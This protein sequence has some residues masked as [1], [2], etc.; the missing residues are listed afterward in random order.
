MIVVDTNVLIYLS[1]GGEKNSL[2]QAVRIADANWVLPPLWKH[3]YLNVLATYGKN[4][5][6]NLTDLRGLWTRAVQTFQPVEHHVDYLEALR[7][8][9]EYSISA[10]DAQYLTLALSLKVPL[11][12]EDKALLKAAPKHAFSMEQFRY[13]YNKS[14]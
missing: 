3:E 2:A 6:L 10:Y 14:V 5:H 4:G 11:I 13:S 1:I 7:V 12:T 8:S 9:L